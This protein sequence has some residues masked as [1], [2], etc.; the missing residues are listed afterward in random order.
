MRWTLLLDEPPRPGWHNMAVDQALLELS[1]SH[2]EG[3]LRCYRWKPFCLS[4][5]R[6]EPA[7]RRYDRDRIDDLGIDVVRRPTGGRAVWHAGELTYAVA[8]P[9][10]VFGTL[11]ETY[12][13]IHTTIR[14]ALTALGVPSGLAGPPDRQTGLA[15]G[16]C[17]SQPVGGEVVVEGRKVVG[18][19]QVREDGALLQHGS[20][21]LE[22]DQ[23]MVAAVTNGEAPPGAEAALNLV[24][25]TPLAAGDVA[26]ALAREAHAWVGE[27]G[28]DRHAA[29]RAAR[30][31][32]LGER[33]RSPTWTWRR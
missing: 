15:G 26:E 18:S 9:A 14:Q 5:G 10:G 22:D 12:Y 31:A 3:F 20:I 28:P 13:H 32:A 27:W 4:F 7:S 33:F 16:A 1:A 23:A 21:L 25:P 6:N 17:F 8:A 2:G 29:E 24:V 30:S 11:R 19:A